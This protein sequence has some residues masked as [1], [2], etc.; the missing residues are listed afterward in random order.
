[1]PTHICL[2]HVSSDRLSRDD[3]DS[4]FHINVTGV[5]LVTQS[6]LPLL[7]KGT[8]KKVVNM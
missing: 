8:L 4:T 6:L 3:L 5:H 2:F 1:M 7:K